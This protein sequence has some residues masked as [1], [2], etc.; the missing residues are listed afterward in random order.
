MLPEQEIK[1]LVSVIIPTYNRAGLL[2]DAVM[3]VFKQTY[4]P[5]ECLVIDDGSTDRSADVIA[6]L[7]QLQQ[8]DFTITYIIQQNAGSQAARNNGT[9]NSSG[10]YIQ[11]LDSDDILYSD[12]LRNQVNYLKQHPDCD[13]V[14]GD[15][16]KGTIEKAELNKAFASNDLIYQLL[17]E[18]SIANFSFLMRRK[19]I[20]KIGD[21]DISI[22][23]NQEIDFHLR[24]L[25]QGAIYHYQELLTGLWRTHDGERIF[26]KT[27]F[28]SA[29]N[30]Y[31]KWERILTEQEIWNGRFK[32]GVSGNYLWFL[33]TY[34][35]SEKKEM[36]KLLYEVYRLQPQHPI[37]NTFKFKLM[38]RIAGFKTAV[39]IWIWRFQQQHK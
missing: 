14:F 27:N 13:G 5:I 4:R 7:Q 28:S 1:N 33:N 3:S 22:K 25:L 31:Q 21:W 10:E 12:K 35:H 16:H 32:D 23:R 19:L 29:I 18:K 39:S 9:I 36:E 8:A 26:S 15:W 6:E 34:P 11:Y 38:Q 2:R 17:A 37:F 30:F 24:G 20:C